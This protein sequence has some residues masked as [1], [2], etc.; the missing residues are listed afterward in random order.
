MQQLYKIPSTTVVDAIETWADDPKICYNITYL[1]K[2]S[3]FPPNKTVNFNATAY[4]VSVNAS[5]FMKIVKV[6][7]ELQ[8]YDV[9]SVKTGAGL[10][11]P[12][13]LLSA[14][15]PSV[16]EVP[17]S[18]LGQ[19]SVKLIVQHSPDLQTWKVS[20]SLIKMNYSNALKV[21]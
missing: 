17:L 19:L 2:I 11:L 13:M 1:S 18:S 14:T 5:G 9:A 20:E 6:Q 4:L 12:K 10:T 21:E 7:W 8:Y 15:T 3:L 16:N